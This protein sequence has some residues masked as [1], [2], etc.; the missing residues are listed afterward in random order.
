MGVANLG[1][2]PAG[3]ILRT[4]AGRET[5]AEERN[6]RVG[7]AGGGDCED[8]RGGILLGLATDSAFD[9]SPGIEKNT[10]RM[11]ALPV[12]R[13]SWR[14]SRGF[15]RRLRNRRGVRLGS[16]L[17]WIQKRGGRRQRTLAAG[18]AL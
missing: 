14:R 5:E 16:R 3:Q 1:K 8:F 10:A 12:L 11:A 9:D 6:E 4:D 13:G 15:C 18:D 2:Q 17:S 7:A